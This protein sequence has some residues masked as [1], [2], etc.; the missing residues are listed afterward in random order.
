MPGVGEFLRIAAQVLD[1][2]VKEVSSVEELALV[3]ME[4]D[5]LMFEE[6]KVGVYVLPSWV[7]KDRQ[8]LSSLV[9]HL[10]KTNKDLSPSLLSP[11]QVIKRR[12]IFLVQYND[13]SR[14]GGNLVELAELMS[15]GR[16]FLTQVHF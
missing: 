8:L 2:W 5:T 1:I 4:R 14:N 13:E 11:K 6:D 7:L 15:M 12:T 16:Y 9:N 3:F 10:K